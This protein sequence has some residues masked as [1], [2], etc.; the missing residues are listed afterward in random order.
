MVMSTAQLGRVQTSMEDRI[1]HKTDWVNDPNQQKKKKNYPEYKMP[2]SLLKGQGGVIS[3]SSPVSARK[4]PPLPRHITKIDQETKKETDKWK[5]ELIWDL[6]G[7]PSLRGILKQWV[8]LG[9]TISNIGQFLESVLYK[10]DDH[11]DGRLTQMVDTH[12]TYTC[13]ALDILKHY[14]I[15]DDYGKPLWKYTTIQLGD[16][17]ARAKQ[18]QDSIL[19]ASVFRDTSLQSSRHLTSTST[20]RRSNDKAD[21]ADN[22]WYQIPPPKILCPF[23]KPSFLCDP[24]ICCPDLSRKP[25]HEGIS[26]SEPPT[27]PFDISEARPRRSIAER[28]A[29]MRDI[30]AHLP[31]AI[32]AEIIEPCACVGSTLRDRANNY[33]QKQEEK[34]KAKQKRYGVVECCDLEF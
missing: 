16:R 14:Q 15:R 18:P 5:D 20:Q 1:A 34:R 10:R 21:K 4:K 6:N 12:R 30:G 24:E 13:I 32:S 9:V 19:P 28:R 22:S 23:Q 3:D 2:H 25:C 31:R 29:S 17:Y 11:L 8:Q 27:Y 33:L 7:V 26:V